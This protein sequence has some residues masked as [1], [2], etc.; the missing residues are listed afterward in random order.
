MANAI[1]KD[2]NG[3]VVRLG[4]YTDANGD[5]ATGQVPLIGGTPV[6]ESN[7]LPVG[8]ATLGLPTDTEASGDGTLVGILKRIRSLL[9]RPL[10]IETLTPTTIVAGASAV[11]VIPANANRKTLEICNTGTGRIYYGYST[12]VT[13]STGYPLESG[14]VVNGQ[15]GSKEW[16]L[17]S[18]PMGA[19]YAFSAEGSTV[20]VVE[21]A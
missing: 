10:L 11:P 18:A 4:I 16:P 7:A 9:A 19:L 1:L 17:G 2:G 6:T 8:G 12:S 13:E 15:G 14:G 5:V 3:G 20:I 21:G